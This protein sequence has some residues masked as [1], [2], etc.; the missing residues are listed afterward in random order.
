MKMKSIALGFY[1]ELSTAQWV[2]SELKQHNFSHFASIHRKRDNSIQINRFFPSAALLISST[3]IITS[4]CLVLLK[5]FQIISFSWVSIFFVITALLAIAGIYILW[6]FS[7]VIDINI[8]NRYKALVTVDEILVIIQLRQ[9]DVREVLAILRQ[10]KS[11]HPVTFLLRPALFEELP[12]EIVS[13]PVTLEQIGKEAAQL[14]ASLQQ[15]GV[16]EDSN[17]SLLKCFQ[18]SNEMLQLLRRDIADAEY[19]EQTV[20]SS[21]EWLLDNI[22]VLEGSIE[23]VKRNLPKKYYKVLP[24]ILKGPLAGFP[25]IYALAVELVKSSAGVLNRENI[26]QFLNNYQTVQPLTIG[27][28][29]AFPLMLRFRLV[30][31]VEYLAVHVD[32]RMREGELASFWGN[33]L[34]YAARHEP[35]RLPVFLEDLSNE[36]CHISSHFAEELLDHLFDEEAV[37]PM[38]R[39]WLEERFK[40]PLDQVLHQEHLDETSEQVVFS[41]SIRS[42][43]TLSQLSWPDIFESVSAV[44]AILR[45]D[46]DSLYTKMDF[47]TRNSYRES[48]EEIARRVHMPEIEVA[49]KTVSLASKGSKDFDQHIGYYLIDAGRQNLEKTVG[50]RPPFLMRLRR[51]IIKHSA[52][53]YLGGIISITA[54]LE[55]GLISLFQIADLNSV[56]TLL[57]AVLSLIPISE[58][59]VQFA[60][61]ILTLILPTALLPKMRFAAGVP[62]EDKTLVVVPMIL[63]KPD[64]ISEEI[65]RL[66]IR[67]LANNDPHI[68]FSLF[69]DFSDAP[70]QHMENDSSLLSVAI[71]GLERLQNKYGAGKFFLFH[72]QRIWSKSENAWIGWERK[73]G[74]L[75]YLNRFL[76]GEQ[77]PERIVYFGDA[78]ALKAIRY[79]ITLDADTQL[80]KDQAKSL[81]E[82][83]SHPLNRPYLTADQKNIERGYTIIQ[84]RVGTDFIHSKASWFSKIFSEPTVVDPYTQAISNVY[85]D[86]VGEGSYHGKGIYDVKAFH[87]ILSHHFPEEHL[88]SHDLIEG[89]FVRAAFAGNICLFDIHPKDYLSWVKRQHRWMRGDWQI[90]DWIKRRV[91]TGSGKRRLTLLIGS[92]AGKFLIIYGVPF[93]QSHSYF[94]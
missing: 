31:W 71:E 66:E 91:P 94:F 6:G 58:L 42:L 79:V 27:E 76:M 20:P 26:T 67:F 53:V 1:Q 57:F 45:G 28:L 90:I 73:R 38:V 29:W 34:L 3:G 84:P 33:R 2:I 46:S 36:A 48:I 5:Y 23:D 60:N 9:K 59:S 65:N 86:L 81:I 40:T 18:K 51:A 14:A 56:Q 64:S 47:N 85:Q 50:F 12:M 77:L 72:R 17:H 80:Q 4:A 87:S 92:T 61:F 88:L 37:L 93:Y 19:I 63:L 13:E 89:A 49:R 75:E 30:E 83:A 21:A 68:I 8:V 39:K 44:D 24:K 43:I 52:P 7:E 69:S 32:N 16:K 74:K 22:Y 54:L 35:S 55:I 10:V 78:D 70:K 25:R 62:Q 41:N 11:G 82:V 15:I